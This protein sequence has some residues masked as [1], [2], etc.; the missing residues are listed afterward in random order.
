MGLSAKIADMKPQ[1]V[2]DAKRITVEALNKHH[3]P[4]GV[5]I[6][7]DVATYIKKEFDLAYP[8]DGKA[9]SGV[10]HCIVGRNFAGSC[11]YET[12]FVIWLTVKELGLDVCCSN[13]RI[14]PTTKV[15]TKINKPI[16]YIKK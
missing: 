4:D 11:T 5:G 12:H 1:M 15:H 14:T 3:K 9:T 7:M 10:Y 8:S 2:T 6:F 13:P 16:L